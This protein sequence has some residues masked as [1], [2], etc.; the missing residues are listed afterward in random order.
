M[1]TSRDD[2]SIAIRSAFLQ[3]G[4]QQR[5]SLVV[6]VLICII[7][8][9]IEAFENKPLNYIRSLVKDAI[10]RGS[11]IVSIPAKIFS[12]SF[13]RAQHHLNLNE[14][15]NNLKI[16][17]DKLKNKVSNHEFLM[18]ENTQLRKLIDEQVVSDFDLVSARVLID[19]KSPY[20]NSFIINIGKNKSILNGMSVLDRENFIGR[21]VD[22][23]FFS[24]RV[25]LITDLNSKIPVIL[26]PS[27]QHAILSGRNDKLPNLEYLPENYVIENGDKVFTSGKE[28]IFLPGIPIGEVKIENG[29]ANVL[30]F[31]DLN[32]ITFV[33]VN[34]NY[35]DN[36]N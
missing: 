10:Y 21:I 7:F 9:F 16:E 27:G 28:G 24:S 18:M 29:I 23:N 14:N 8:L 2:V 19:K 15:Y 5:F 17:N 34:L 12:S 22:V 20:L 4:A 6:L 36:N 33:N 1:D 11:V 35:Q 3:K 25:L 13:D 32:Q 31:S 30:L 26:E